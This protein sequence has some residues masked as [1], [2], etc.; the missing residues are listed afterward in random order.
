MTPTK[1][2][3]SPPISSLPPAS[4][5]QE[6]TIT[7]LLFRQRWIEVNFRT[8]LISR[9]VQTTL[10]PLIFFR[11]VEWFWLLTWVMVWGVHVSIGWGLAWYYRRH[12]PSPSRPANL[13]LWCKTRILY[14]LTGWGIVGL[15][16]VFCFWVGSDSW[17][18]A[19]VAGTAMILVYA[20]FDVALRGE[21]VA[22][23]IGMSLPL[24][25]AL[26]WFATPLYLA[27]AALT[28]GMAVIITLW[29]MQQIGV[30][31]KEILMRL[32]LEAEKERAEQANLAK[33]R[34][35]AAASHDLRQPLHAL[36]LFTAALSERLRSDE[37]P[38]LVDNI[39]RSVGAL[40]GLLNALLDISKLDAGS[41]VP[42][43]RDF[44]LAFLLAQLSSEY[45]PQARSKGLAWKCPSSDLVVHTDPALL[46][47][48]LRNL[49][50]NALRYT[51]RG[52]V[53]VECSREGDTVCIAVIDTGIGI[54]AEH[55]QEIFAEFV[56]LHNPE[57]DRGKGLGLGLAIVDRLVQLLDHRLELES[58]TVSGSTFRLL[59]PLGQAVPANPVLPKAEPTDDATTL[60]T[61][62]VIDDESEVREAMRT[63]LE[64]WG[65]PVCAVGSLSEALASLQHA[66]GAII[67]DYRLREERTGAE[68]IRTLRQTFGEDI[69]ALIVTGDTAPERIRQAR[70]SGFAFLHKPVPPAKLRAFLR[71]S[72]QR[73]VAAVAT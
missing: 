52:A 15:A 35:L 16:P 25:V 45:E 67:A 3:S 43:F 29:G 68:A 44:S 22:A 37:A 42:Q 31:R 56:Q 49:I 54:A 48:I 66:P 70:E 36:G 9:L 50:S 26:L 58:T 8:E 61:V 62:L 17:V 28:A 40:E 71:S 60:L 1:P 59:L 14:Q 73:R 38:L 4:A 69:P 13:K 7:D 65:Y 72:G 53:R 63:L 51:Q 10:P 32:M 12:Y 41:V 23:G 64:T 57:R 18:I 55:Q 11:Y 20:P 34:F 6:Q 47:T 39:K 24:L 19:G 2:A 33:S 27:L 5:E 46:E 30:A 21:I